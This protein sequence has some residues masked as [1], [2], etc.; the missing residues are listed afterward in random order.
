MIIGT[1]YVRESKFK[2]V[3]ALSLPTGLYSSY[4]PMYIHTCDVLWALRDVIS[5][6][7]MEVGNWCCC[8][9]MGTG[10]RWAV[11]SGTHPLACVG[12]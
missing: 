2:T 5:S 9:S 3:T 11:N 8:S 1:M 7:G 4:I 10:D 6:H 12:L